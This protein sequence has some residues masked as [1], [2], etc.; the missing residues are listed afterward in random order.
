MVEV[1][2]IY[3]LWGKKKTKIKKT[4]F[5]LKIKNRIKQ[6][7]EYCTEHDV[8][9]ETV[10]DIHDCSVWVDGSERSEN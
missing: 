2:I 7:W 5:L 9:R 1:W 6:T 10:A 4:F 3:G 8:L